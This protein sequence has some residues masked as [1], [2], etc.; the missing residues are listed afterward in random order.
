MRSLVSA[1]HTRIHKDIICLNEISLNL[2]NYGM[3]TAQNG[4]PA[5]ARVLDHMSLIP[6]EMSL[7]SF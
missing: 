6:V 3:V 2:I 5:H 1:K 7:L 4:N